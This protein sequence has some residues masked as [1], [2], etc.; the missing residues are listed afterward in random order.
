MEF[1]HEI[2]GTRARRVAEAARAWDALLQTGT[3]DNRKR[4]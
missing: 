4:F 3:N 2:V 1:E